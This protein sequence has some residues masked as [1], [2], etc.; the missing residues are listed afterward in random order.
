M[1][2]AK[3]SRLRKRE[4]IIG[5]QQRESGYSV[6]FSLSLL[7]GLVRFKGGALAT[8]LVVSQS[9]TTQRFYLHTAM[10]DVEGSK[11]SGPKRDIV[12]CAA[13]VHT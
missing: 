6:A 3:Q 4:T 9:T 11:C 10:E 5:M 13:T 2:L 7:A 1:V 12:A 8:F